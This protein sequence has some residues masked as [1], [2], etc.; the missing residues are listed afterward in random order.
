[1]TNQEIL[2]KLTNIFR[3]V[4]NDDS[5]LLSPSLNAKDIHGWDSLA[6]IRIVI[7]AE[8]YFGIKFSSI[9]VSSWCTIA[10]VISSI[11]NHLLDE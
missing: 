7:T 1:M 6:H 5:I 11:S 8:S 3:E 2:D 4:F 10:D 9:E